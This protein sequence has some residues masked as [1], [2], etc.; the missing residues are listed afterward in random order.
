MTDVLMLLGNFAFHLRTA[1]YDELKRVSSYRWAAQDRIGRKPAQQ[2][3]GTGA[4]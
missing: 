3:L 4:A 2:F 1:A